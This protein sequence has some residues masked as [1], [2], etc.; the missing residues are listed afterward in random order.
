M[1]DSLLVILVGIASLAIT[2]IAVSYLFAIVRRKK[3]RCPQCGARTPVAR[4][5]FSDAVSGQKIAGEPD[6]PFALFSGGARM[7]IGV[8]AIVYVFVRLIGA[9]GYDD[10]YLQGI[11]MVC[12]YDYSSI[13]DATINL[14]YSL[15][16]IVGGLIVIVNGLTL[17][18]RALSARGKDMTYEFICVKDHHWTQPANQIEG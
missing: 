2:G 11:N 6:I 5:Y 16:G 13:P 15:V 7:F 8:I 17:F 10:C 3:M 9:L 4:A 14:F 1:F 12:A 18:M